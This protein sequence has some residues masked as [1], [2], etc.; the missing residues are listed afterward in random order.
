MAKPKK[1]LRS[2]ARFL[3]TGEI[4]RAVGC[5]PNTVRLYEE[6]GY[7]QPVPRHPRSS[8]RMFTPRH[9]EQMRLAW[10]ALKYPYPGGKQVV[11]DLVHQAA[12]DEFGAA[13]E[14]AYTYLAQ[15]QAETAHA[16]TAIAFVERWVRG[17]PME[18]RQEPLSISQAARLLNLSPDT[19]R[20]WER[21]GLLKVPRNPRNNYRQYGPQEIGRLRVLR[22][23]RQAGYSLM[24]IL[25]LMLE[26]DS[27]TPQD[28]RAIL[29][30]PRPDSEILHIADRW[31]S[32][33]QEQETRA[34]AIIAQL[35][36]MMSGN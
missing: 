21:N 16:E 24:A 33:L 10:L 36:N 8:Y 3:R 12:R 7:L 2:A 30:T 1:K 14:S 9:L 31:L 19:L 4:A 35:E 25:Q 23:L 22:M 32:T 34:R 13:M 15:V 26:L 28:L 27:G 29:D 6:W 18:T 5:H 20:D 17:V 11:L